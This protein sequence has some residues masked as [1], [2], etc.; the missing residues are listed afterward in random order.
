MD[1][2]LMKVKLKTEKLLAGLNI[3]KNVVG[4]DARV[5]MLALI[6]PKYNER[7]EGYVRTSLRMISASLADF[8]IDLYEDDVEICDQTWDNFYIP[9]MSLSEL[10]MI[11]TK[12]D[13]SGETEMIF[14]KD[15]DN[16][17]VHA[18]FMSAS[19]EGVSISHD[20][21]ATEER[22]KHGVVLDSMDSE[23]FNLLS[24]ENVFEEGY[25][26]VPITRTQLISEL[27]KGIQDGNDT[28]V[29]SADISAFWR[30]YTNPIVTFTFNIQQA[31]MICTV[32][33]EYEAKYVLIWESREKTKFISD[34]E[35]NFYMQLTPGCNDIFGRG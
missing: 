6:G 1:S 9:N 22:G 26:I 21:S 5:V 18:K 30:A 29:V 33:K 12:A 17:T 16:L 8:C 10:L 23:R 20:F 3:L 34:D 35:N 15:G 27:S 4:E 19:N 28:I 31:K 25:A 7:N 11:I 14:E 32:I 13:K 24:Y 2:K